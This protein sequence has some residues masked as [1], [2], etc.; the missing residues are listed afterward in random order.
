MSGQEFVTNLNLKGLQI[1]NVRIDNIDS[2]TAPT[3][4]GKGHIVTLNDGSLNYNNGSKWVKLADDA[5]LQD[6]KTTVGDSSS[7]LVKD[8]KALQ[9]AIGT[10]E[11]GNNLTARVAALETAVGKAATDTTDATGL[12]ADIKTNKTSIE[13]NATDITAINTA[14]GDDT[15]AGTVKGRIKTLEGEM[16]TAQSDIDA[17]EAKVGDTS[18]GLVADVASLKMTV[19]DSSSGLVKRVAD[20]ETNIGKKANSDDVYT[21]TQIDNKFTETN[22][23]V[24]TNANAISTLQNA[25]YITKDADNLTNYY[26]KEETYT[27]SEVDS[28][29]TA[30]LS[31]AYKVKGSV[32]MTELNALSEKEN[33]DVYNVSDAFS[34]GST[35]YPAG[36]NVVWVVDDAATKAGHWDP[37]AGLTD[38][39]SYS[40][41]DGVKTLISTAKSEA[42]ST[43]KSYTETEAAKLVPQTTTVNGHPLSANVTVTASDV[44]LG[45]VN[46]TSDTDKP[47][48]TATQTALDNKVDKLASKP[49]ADTYTKVTINT[50][51]QVTA[52]ATLEVS[53]IPGLTSA[54]ISDFA[55]AS[56][57][58]GKK[59]YTVTFQDA[60]LGSYKYTT[61]GEVTAF[62]SAITVYESTGELVLAG[63][64]YDST[65]KRVG[66]ESNIAGTYTVVVSL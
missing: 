32:T 14:I 66:I 13:K 65:N 15:T 22:G 43:A 41:T 39:S 27:Q 62:P 52:G 1:K 3:G 37:L 46:N 18:R 2:D 9:D 25:G 56:V 23:K 35:S 44:G 19:G 36:T 51:G 17:L 8:V 12:Y 26:K 4:L 38:L 10:D 7:G 31:S 42:I 20:N 6:V 11:S 47:V 60:D 59:T 29:V 45:N 57:T 24:S 48:S 53:D 49:S 28:K 16:G 58:A 30:A 61:D 63:A 33:G 55:S 50:E 34:D 40:T 64:K 21:K 54:K 5:V